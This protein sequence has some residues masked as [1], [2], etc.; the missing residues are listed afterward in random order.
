MFSWDAARYFL[1]KE[2]LY[3]SS[4]LNQKHLRIASCQQIIDLWGPAISRITRGSVKYYCKTTLVSSLRSSSWEETHSSTPSP[5]AGWRSGSESSHRERG[6]TA[7]EQTLIAAS[8]RTNSSTHHMLHEHS[9]VVHRGHTSL[10]LLP[11]LSRVSCFDLIN[12][13]VRLV[14]GS[15]PGLVEVIKTREGFETQWIKCS[16]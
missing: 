16:T 5:A 15:L 3:Y 14:H 2:K 6:C 7:K 13:A 10:H 11:V 1:Y 8:W 4:I 12:G 9:L